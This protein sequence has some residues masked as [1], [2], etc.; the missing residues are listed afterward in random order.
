M[1]STP[2]KPGALA[3]ATPRP[4][5]IVSAADVESRSHRYPESPDEPMAP[6]RAIGQA[7]G[8][9]HI[10]LHIHDVEPGQRI[11]FPHAESHEEEF[12]LVLEGEIDAW[13]DGHLH[14]VK[15]GDLVAFPAGTGICHTF[16]NNGPR[17]AQLL[18]GGDTGKEENRI[19]YP[20]HPEVEQRREDW[21]T[22]IT[23]G[24]Q[25]PHDGLP[26]AVRAGKT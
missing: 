26:D 1:P 16:I 17:P 18:G 6:A 4:S 15:K 20:L 25:G 24:A 12:V 8:L 23:L 22:D 5:F 2:S 11:S 21:W 9:K 10:G 19:F 3:A 14:R 7:A 13:I